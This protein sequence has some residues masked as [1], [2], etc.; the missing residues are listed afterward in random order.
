LPVFSTI[1]NYHQAVHAFARQIIELYHHGDKEKAQALMVYF[2]EEREK[3]FQG[4]D[5]MYLA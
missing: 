4:M 5:E 3:L 2:E 1:D